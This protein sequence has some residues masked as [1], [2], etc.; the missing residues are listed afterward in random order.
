MQ[1]VYGIVTT[2]FSDPITK[3]QLRRR[4]AY[5]QSRILNSQYPALPLGLHVPKCKKDGSFESTQCNEGFCW[6]VDEEGNKIHQQTPSRFQRP[7]CD[8]R[9]FIGLLFH[10]RAGKTWHFFSHCFVIYGDNFTLLLRVGG[11]ANSPVG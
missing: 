8:K 7:N 3:C 5:K 10:V 2:L 11:P 4:E 6:C 9:K 1:G